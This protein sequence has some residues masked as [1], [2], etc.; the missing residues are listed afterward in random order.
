MVLF[1][2]IIKKYY[3]LLGMLKSSSFIPHLKPKISLL[4]PW[5]KE[6]YL[7]PEKVNISFSLII[8]LGTCM[9]ANCTYLVMPLLRQIIKGC[10]LSHNIRK[11][12]Y[13]FGKIIETLIYF[14][15][16]YICT[17]LL[18]KTYKNTTLFLFFQQLHP[19]R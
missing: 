5:W 14:V 11:M 10:V 7:L 3:L 15:L 8:Y 9:L 13:I 16:I 1:I 19:C 17:P 18:L 6:V 12:S 4:L 2:Y